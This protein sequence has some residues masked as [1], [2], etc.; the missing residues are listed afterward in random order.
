MILYC[1]IIIRLVTFNQH[2]YYSYCNYALV[3]C[4]VAAM[5]S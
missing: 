1:T 4:H 3:D 5:H 2:N